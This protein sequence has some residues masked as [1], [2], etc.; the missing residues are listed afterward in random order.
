M[1]LREA[2]AVESG[3]VLPVCSS[4]VTSVAKRPPGR[5][6]VAVLSVR[7]RKAGGKRPNLCHFR[8]WRWDWLHSLAGDPQGTGNFS[9]S[10][11]G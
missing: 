1:L 3:K 6:S 4:W 7:G 8:A 2:D 9:H 5:S 10:Y 11:C